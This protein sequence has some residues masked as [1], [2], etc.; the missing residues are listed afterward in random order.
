MERGAVERGGSGGGAVE[1]GGSGE[2]GSGEERRRSEQMG[3]SCTFACVCGPKG[4]CVGVVC[5]REGWLDCKSVCVGGCG[6]VDQTVCNGLC[7]GL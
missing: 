5:V 7:G 6:C 4:L 3:R 1:R 2:G